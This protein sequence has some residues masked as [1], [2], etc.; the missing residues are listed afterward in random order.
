MLARFFDGALEDFGAFGKF[1]SYIY[2]RRLGVDGETGDRDPLQQLMRVFMDDV[3]VL[4]C[5]GLR[6]VRITN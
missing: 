3:T 5:S 2:V 6:F 4:E 1:A